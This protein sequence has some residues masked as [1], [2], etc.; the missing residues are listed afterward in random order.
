MNDKE[1]FE[2][3]F[4]RYKHEESQVDA[5]YH[6]VGFLLTALP[7]L[8]AVAYHL[9][10]AEFLRKAFL[11]VDVFIYV[12]STSA[13]F[14]CLSLSALFLMW[15]V[16]PR[17]YKA[18]NVMREWDAKRADFKRW[19]ESNKVD[20][21]A[22]VVSTLT[23]GITSRTMEAE[24]H[25]RKANESRR[26]KFRWSIIWAGIAL[27]FIALEGFFSMILSLQGVTAHGQ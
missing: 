11:R 8:G 15:C 7:V 3:C 19:D 1:F 18:L 13:S 4:D 9:G 27:A 17:G 20:N 24:E 16:L 25:Y 10:Q 22:E 6:R 14:V 12:A 5:I 2:L 26:Q 21:Q 23:K